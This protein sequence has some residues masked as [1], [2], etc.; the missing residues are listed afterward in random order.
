MFLFVPVEHLQSNVCLTADVQQ[1]CVL[2]RVSEQVWNKR[3]SFPG[4]GKF[5]NQKSMMHEEKK[6]FIKA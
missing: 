2:F 5:R 1:G 4:S 6:F 3:N